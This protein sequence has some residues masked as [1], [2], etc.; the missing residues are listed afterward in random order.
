MTAPAAARVP[1][2][3]RAALVRLEDV[4]FHPRNVRRDLGDL[5]EL[6]ASIARYGVM[7]PIV[8]EV[9]GKKLRLRAGHRRVAAARLAGL[10]RVPGMVHEHALD[11]DEWT[12]Q[13]LHENYHRRGLDGDELRDAC[14]RLVDLGVTRARIAEDLGVHVTTV[15]N[16][17]RDPQPQGERPYKD[18]YARRKAAGTGKQ[19]RQTAI[20]TFAAAW[21][22]RAAAGDVTVEQLLDA[23]DRVAEL[24]RIGDA[25][26]PVHPPEAADG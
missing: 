22:E 3:A 20:G 26:P 7:Q 21:R 24:G 11:D 16:W 4:E 8:V 15:A 25:L 10:T 19:I 2:Q 17:L 18:D 14:R 1:P 23:L 9:H 6:T 5:R 12:L 13:A